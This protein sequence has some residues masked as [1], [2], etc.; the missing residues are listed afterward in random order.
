MGGRGGSYARSGGSGGGGGAGGTKDVDELRQYMQD[1]YGVEVKSSV[2]G[3]NFDVVRSA[4]AEIEY[5]PKEF[6]KAAGLIHVLNGDETRSSA[7]ASATFHGALQLSPKMMGDATA[8]ANSYARDVS[9]RW[10][11]EGTNERHIATHELGHLLEGAMVHLRHTD[12]G[13]YGTLD[14]INAW[15]KHKYA[16]QVVSEAARAVKKTAQGRGLTNDQLV[17]QVSRYA[18]KNRSE[19]LAEA[20]ADYRANGLNAKPLSIEI[21][22][23][24]KREL[25]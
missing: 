24:L 9:T 1:N 18:T 13:Y 5:I 10:H 20:V 3:M 4:A 6:P 15:N 8:L 21:W 14:R 16:T 19:T 25:G 23:V 12:P 2:D 17:S 22:K 11:P 7:Y